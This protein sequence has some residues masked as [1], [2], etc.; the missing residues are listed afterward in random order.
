MRDRG[1][2]G[3]VLRSRGGENRFAG[4][5]R[6]RRGDAWGEFR[7]VETGDSGGG[8]A[9]RTGAGRIVSV[10]SARLRVSDG[11]GARRGESRDGEM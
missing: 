3:V 11:G 10:L 8:D 9:G 2:S 1:A 7:G 4:V 5:T 6:G